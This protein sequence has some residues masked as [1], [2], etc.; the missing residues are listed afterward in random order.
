MPLFNGAREQGVDYF[1]DMA[2]GAPGEGG[3]FKGLGHDATERVTQQLTPQGLAIQMPCLACSAGHGITID[4]EELF[5]VASNG[6]GL[7]P[8]LPEG[9]GYSNV[10][11]MAFPANLYCR[12]SSGAPENL[13]RIAPQVS[14]EEAAECVQQGIAQSFIHPAQM[15]RWQ[16]QV[17]M[18]RQRHG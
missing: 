17:Q 6:P 16:A 2:E 9:W 8:L 5:Y 3:V 4:W 12:A 14:P 11:N 18:Y 1:D 13:R 7:S 10:N 15:Q